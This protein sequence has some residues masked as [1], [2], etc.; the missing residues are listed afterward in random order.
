MNTIRFTSPLCI[1]PSG[2]LICYKRGEIIIYNA[3][4]VEKRFLIFSDKK[5]RVISRCKFLF[6][7]LRLGIRTSIAID[8]SHILFSKGNYLFELD[9]LSERLSTGW[10][11]GD[12]IRPLVFTEVNGI[13]GFGD[14]ILFGGY[15]G[16]NRE[17]KPV[18]VYKRAS[19]DQWEIVYTFEQGVINH[20]HNIVAD[21]YRQCL[22]AFTGDSDEASAIWKITDNFKKVER[23]VGNSQQYR[24]CVVF[25]IK[26]GLLYATDAPSVKNFIYLMNSDTMKFEKI[27]PIDGSCIYGCQCGDK[28]VFSSSVEPDGRNS[29]F[30]LL[31]NRKRGA[32]IFDM[33][34]HLYCG[35][36][37]KGFKEI[38]KEKKDLWPY[39]FQFGVFRFPYGKNKTNSLYF[40]PVGT[41]RNDLNLLTLNLSLLR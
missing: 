23:V 15:L 27:A 36:L 33:Y 40:Q 10:F 2:R 41:N 7:L 1:L 32:G 16:N 29:L 9:L 8:E 3:G 31:T 12:G 24:G 6:R 26:E 14:C 35:N 37:E 11:V 34:A 28:F 38:Y 25:P 5:E 22:W 30:K 13:Q 21:P 39:L 20:I 4:I 19:M 18:H 17:K